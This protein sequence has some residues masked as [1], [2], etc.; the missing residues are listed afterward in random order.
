M[1][2]IFYFL[3]LV[4]VSCNEAKM[5]HESIGA[6]DAAVSSPMAVE[7]S[8]A[9]IEPVNGN[10]VNLNTYDRKIIKNALLTFES[11]KPE[12][13][14]RLITQLVTKNQGYLISNNQSKLDNLTEYRISFKVPFQKFDA[15]LIDLEKNG[16]TLIDKNVSS[17]DVTEEFIDNESQVKAQKELEQRYLQLVKQAKTIK[18][19]LEIEAKLSEVRANLERIEGRQRFLE[20]NTQFSQFEIVILDKDSQLSNNYFTKLKNSFKDGWDNIFTLV[21]WFIELLPFILA[22]FGIYY[23]IK[24]K[25]ISLNLFNKKKD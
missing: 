4:L 11:E 15:V 17:Q 16:G 2:W 19:M 6:S 18:D 3:S 22:I 7:E 25:K 9:A 24:K 20:N 1:K 5:S 12:E 8:K 10:A 21:L 23:F 14:V 13:N